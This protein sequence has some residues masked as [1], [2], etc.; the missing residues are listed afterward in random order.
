[1]LQAAYGRVQAIVNPVGLFAV[2]RLLSKKISRSRIFRDT[3]KHDAV[4]QLFD[5]IGV[6]A[7]VIE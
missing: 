7:S 5:A 1:M 2:I 4:G 3:P 6:E